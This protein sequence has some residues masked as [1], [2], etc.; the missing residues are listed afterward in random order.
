MA[1]NKFVLSAMDYYMA[2]NP[3][4]C[5]IHPEIT[6]KM[7]EQAKQYPPNDCQECFFFKWIFGGEKRT[8]CGGS[9]AA[10]REI[11]ANKFEYGEIPECCPIKD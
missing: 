8:I 1:K 5:S 3:V 10:N 4:F 9:C 2:N 6:N 7:I 11:E